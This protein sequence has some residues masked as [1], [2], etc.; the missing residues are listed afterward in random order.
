VAIHGHCHTAETARRD[1]RS[2]WR[3]SD[4]SPVTAYEMPDLSR[5][6]GTERSEP[7]Y[8]SFNPYAERLGTRRPRPRISCPRRNCSALV[9]IGQYAVLNHKSVDNCDVETLSC[10]SSDLTVYSS[11]SRR[12]ARQAALLQVAPGAICHP[13]SN[14][15]GTTITRSSEKNT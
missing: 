12:G 1:D 4:F 9:R 13:G 10:R 8:R 2:G 14:D 5:K 11:S 3:V 7:P 15:F 6:T